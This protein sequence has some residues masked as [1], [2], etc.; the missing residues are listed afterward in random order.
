V[1]CYNNLF[2]GKVPAKTTVPEHACRTLIHELMHAVTV[3]PPKQ[4]AS[5]VL[6]KKQID[7]K[8]W[9]RA[10]KYCAWCLAKEAL[11]YL[12]AGMCEGKACVR[13]AYDSCD[14]VCD[15]PFKDLKIAQEFVKGWIPAAARACQRVKGVCGL[16]P[17]IGDPCKDICC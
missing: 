13:K 4:D 9:S 5:L 10:V 2:G 15:L 16:K 12:C 14:E 3:C 6:V 11:A 1:L 17:T 8:S 7:K